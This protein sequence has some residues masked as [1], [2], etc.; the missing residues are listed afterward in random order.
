MKPHR[1]IS[2]VILAGGRARRMGGID[3]GLVELRGRPLIRYV[4]DTLEGQ[5]DSIYINA[6]RNRDTYAHLGHPVIGDLRTG[7]SG[8]LA[9]MAAALAT[10]RTRYLV[11]VP[12]DCPAL[13]VDLVSR[14]S[15]AREREDAELAV[16]HDG[17]RLQPVCALLDRDLLPSLEAYL[18]QGGHKIDTWYAR[19][20]MATAE[21]S[22]QPEAFAN[23]NTPEDLARMERALEPQRQVIPDFKEQHS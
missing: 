22:D 3:K 2:A 10:A 12:C 4:L 17:M 8:P 23:V 1:D 19:H 6:N 9:G 16:C 15:A 20:R 11:T 13:P 18:D 14:L 21:Y 7:F 5:V